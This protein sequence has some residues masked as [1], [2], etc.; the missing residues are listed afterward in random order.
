MNT[1]IASRLFIIIL[2]VLI[3]GLL[4]FVGRKGYYLLLAQ[5]PGVGGPPSGV[6]NFAS[7]NA[8]YV[9]IQPNAS[10]TNEVLTTQ[11]STDL[12]ADSAGRDL[13]SF[14]IP[15]DDIFGAF[16]RFSAVITS[17]ISSISSLIVSS[18]GVNQHILL[19]PSG[20][21]RVKISGDS[22]VVATLSSDPTGENGQIYYDSTLN[23]FK[24]FENG[25]FRTIPQAQPSGKLLQASFDSSDSA[26][27][28]NQNQSGIVPG[29]TITMTTGNNNIELNFTLVVRSNGP[30]GPATL[31]S[32]YFFVVD[33]V[34]V[35]SAYPFTVTNAGNESSP[36]STYTA[37]LMRPISTGTHTFQV[38]ASAGGNHTLE[39]GS[40]L[41]IVKEIAP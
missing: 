23:K 21:G 6:G 38:R 39:V 7:L 33:G 11:L 1:K 37:T 32:N 2:V 36:V 26:L 14:L 9:V 40:G 31:R 28:L 5:P 34:D 4:L 12:I 8:T 35:G 24:F 29:M 27:N 41:L 25:I 30:G 3:F 20:T 19:N 18:G 15:W 22:L 16:G 10:L 17:Q 13:G